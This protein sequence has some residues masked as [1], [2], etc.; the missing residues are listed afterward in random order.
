MA[1]S[2]RRGARGRRT[3]RPVDWVT[4]F[5]GYNRNDGPVTSPSSN[6]DHWILYAHGDVQNIGGLDWSY[7]LPQYDGIIERVRGEVM[8]WIMPDTSWWNTLTGIL[9][10]KFRLEVMSLQL[11]GGAA[12]F[13]AQPTVPYAS[14]ATVFTPVG[15]NVEFMWEKTFTFIAESSWGDLVIDPAL[16]IQ[17]EDVDVRVKRKLEQNQGLVLTVASRGYDYAGNVI[18]FPDVVTDWE[19]RTLVSSKP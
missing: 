12:N 5:Q 4:T 1:R 9:L 3:R 18:A 19:L 2:F 7:A 14:S 16:Y 15:G 6:I 8:C 17:R 10:V 11:T 13:P